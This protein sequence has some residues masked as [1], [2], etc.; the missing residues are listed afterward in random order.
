MMPYC[1]GCGGTFQ[2]GFME[3]KWVPLEPVESH[4]DMDRTYV[5]EHGQLRADH[6]DR[7]ENG[8]SVN[9]TRLQMKVPATMAN[10]PGLEFDEHIKRS[11][12]IGRFRKR[13]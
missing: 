10:T 5:D 6:R 12:L 9:V 8:V 13:M 7:H 11:G 4:A 2:W 1:Q 3:G